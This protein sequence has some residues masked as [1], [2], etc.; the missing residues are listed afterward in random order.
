MFL[1]P[2]RAHSDFSFHFTLV[3][4]ICK[5]SLHILTCKA[6]KIEGSTHIFGVAY[7]L[8]PNLSA[9]Y[10][11]N[12]VTEGSKVQTEHREGKK[13]EYSD[14]N[15][16]EKIIMD[17]GEN[18]YRKKTYNFSNDEDNILSTDMTSNLVNL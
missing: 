11:I 16:E 17:T 5:S 7:S 10:D 14:K 1:L 8:S 15:R 3:T 9:N 2:S 18:V 6:K 4:G 13:D 12:T